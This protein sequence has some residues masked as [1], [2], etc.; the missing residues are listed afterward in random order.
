MEGNVR[1][2]LLTAIAPITWGASYLVTRQLLPADS[3]LWGAVLRALPAGLLLLLITRTLPRGAWWWRAALLGTLNIGA[4]FVLVY[5][6]AQLLPSSIASMLMAVSP[7]VMLLL[8]WPLLAERPRA[9]SVIGAGL[10]FLGVCAMLL[11]GVERTNLWGVLASV[12]AMVM[13]S[14]GFV[15]S[16][17]WAGDDVGPLP[18]ASWQLVAGGLLVVPV[19]LAVEGAPPRLD[20]VE[21]GAFAFLSLVATA[22][23]Y[24]A[25]FSGLAHLDAGAVG[26]IGLLNPVTGVL[27]GT[28]VAAE[29]LS[30]LQAAGMTLVLVGIVLGQRRTTSAG[31]RLLRRRAPQPGR[32]RRPGHPPGAPGPRPPRTGQA[33]DPAVHAPTGPTHAVVAS[34]SAAPYSPRYAASIAAM[35]IFDIAN[36]ASRARVDAGSPP[37]VSSSSRSG[38]I[39]HDSPN[40]SVHH[41]HGPG[42]PPSAVRA[43]Q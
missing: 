4:F 26:L 23:A 11:T 9:L 2:G 7:A 12:T 29:R 24:W 33:A 1:W 25:W 35:S 22:L 31:V 21:I 13:S 42:L 18:L 30:L 19:A 37:I 6:A 43:S 41:P 34:T 8:A 3:A 15:L 27:L 32:H 5:V 40:R 14:L 36:I 17:R 20:G 10:G 38:T 16:K 28:L 39:C